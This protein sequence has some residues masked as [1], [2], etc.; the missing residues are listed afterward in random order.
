MK[1]AIITQARMS[2][3]RLPGKVLLKINH[4]TLLEYHLERVQKSEIPVIVATSTDQKDDAIFQLCEIIKVPVFRGDLNNVLSRYYD[5]ANKFNLDII[6]RVTSDCPLIDGELIVKGLAPFKK[7][8]V[9]YLSNTVKRTFP[10]G[11]DFEIF[12]MQALTT[13]Y[14]NANTTFETE[15]VTPFIWQNKQKQFTIQAFTQKSD[16]SRYR[17]AVDTKQDF[18]AVKELIEKYQANTKTVAEI[19]K[20]LDSHPEIVRINAHIEQKSV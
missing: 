3:T 1:T 18:D 20:L 7:Q 14:Q 2:S 6:I 15:H 8:R 11:F 17:I 12:T 16:S 9:D 5:C 13:A 10:R 19:I 4:K